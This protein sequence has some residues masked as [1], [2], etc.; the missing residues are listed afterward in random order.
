PLTMTPSIGSGGYVAGTVRTATRRPAAQSRVH[1]AGTR[2]QLPL[3]KRM[4]YVPGTRSVK[5]STPW[6]P[7]FTPVTSDVHAGNVAAG[8]VDRSRPHAPR[9]SSAPSAGSSP[10]A[11]RGRTRSSVAPSSPIT[12]SGVIVT[13]PPAPGGSLDVA[14]RAQPLA[15]PG[16]GG[17]GLLGCARVGA[18]LDDGTSE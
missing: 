12:S 4:R 5:S 3:T 17:A 8:T 1:S 15:L 9:A 6:R 16:R 18:R 13:A 10:A 14:E 11:T 2:R 7:G